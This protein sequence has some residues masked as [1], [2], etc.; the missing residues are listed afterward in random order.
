MLA[1]PASLAVAVV[2]ELLIPP[3]YAVAIVFAVPIVVAAWLSSTS[4]TIAVG[5]VAVVLNILD[6]YAEGVPVALWPI[7]VLPLGL[8]Y[9]LSVQVGHLRETEQQRTRDAEAAREQLREFV[10]LVVHDLRGPLTVTHGYLQILERR[11]IP[12]GDDQ[13]RIPIDQMDRGLHRVLRL[14]SDL[15]DVAR[16]ERG[17]F[18]IQPAPCNLV[19]LVREVVDGQRLTDDRHQYIVNTPAQV[20]GA[21]GRVRLEQVL[22]NLLTNAAKFSAPGTD[23]QV[24]VRSDN[25]SVVL[26]VADQGSGIAPEAIGQL[27]QPFARVGRERDT[28]G[29]G[30]GLYITKSIVEAH[31][32]R[33]WVESVVGRGTTFF[34]RLPRDFRTN[35]PVDASAHHI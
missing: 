6:Y 17:H 34:V 31:G 24:Q 2:V 13:V 27:F 14:V 15:L 3:R 29:T 20:T 5:M 30:L 12:T 33:I 22:T 11:L 32:G 35:G 18:V 1:V 16:I 28:S 7:G 21:W 9:V 19:D 26:S 25:A 10:S 8:I 4:V 23:I